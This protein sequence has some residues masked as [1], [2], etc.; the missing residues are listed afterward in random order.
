MFQNLEKI[1]EDAKMY[2]HAPVIRC[3]ESQRANL[4]NAGF[5]KSQKTDFR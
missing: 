3:S 5:G 4:K 2:K 1:R